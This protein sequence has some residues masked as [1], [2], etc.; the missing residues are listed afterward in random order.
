MFFKIWF[1]SLLTKSLAAALLL[2]FIYTPLFGCGAYA[3]GMIIISLLDL[4]AGKGLSTIPSIVF[5]VIAGFMLFFVGFHSFIYLY[6]A[7]DEAHHDEHHDE[8]HKKEE[9]E[10][11]KKEVTKG[12]PNPD[13]R[14]G[15]IQRGLQ[16]ADKKA[17]EIITDADK[18]KQVDDKKEHEEKQAEEKNCCAKFCGSIFDFKFLNQTPLRF[19]SAIIMFMAV[20]L[21]ESSWTDIWTLRETNS[22]ISV[23]IAVVF[24]YF[25][26]AMLVILLGWLVNHKLLGEVLNKDNSKIIRGVACA[27]LV[28]L[29]FIAIF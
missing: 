22:F 16:H 7:K 9:E 26:D 15:L 6:E 25:V 12:N 23:F 14:Q 2:S 20:N 21:T 8:E 18:K 24:V 3:L 4:V 13:E 1:D 5:R 28:F 29:A 27:I 19:L 17:K 11:K 10:H